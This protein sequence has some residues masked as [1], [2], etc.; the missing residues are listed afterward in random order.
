[1]EDVA[2]LAVP[3][4]I[5]KGILYGSWREL[6]IVIEFLYL[7][8]LLKA[9]LPYKVKGVL[10]I[11]TVR[12]AIL[13]VGFSLVIVFLRNRQVGS[14]DKYLTPYIIRQYQLRFHYID[15]PGLMSVIN[16]VYLL[17]KL[18]LI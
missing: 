17:Y 4:I 5:C 1:M 8:L 11:Y 3:I 13:K 14:I 12:K 18:R 7:Y 2:L 6:S 15:N 16:P 10:Q 9:E